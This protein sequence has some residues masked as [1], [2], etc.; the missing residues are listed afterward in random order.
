MSHLF[1]QSLAAFVPPLIPASIVF[2]SS[3]GPHEIVRQIR[4]RQIAI[5]V[6]VPKALEVLRDFLVYRFPDA[7]TN[8]HLWSMASSLVANPRDPS[9]VRDRWRPWRGGTV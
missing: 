9:H 2:I 3:T 1:G 8:G 4:S 6:S 7:D 5:L